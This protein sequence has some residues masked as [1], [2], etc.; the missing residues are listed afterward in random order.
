[1]LTLLSPMSGFVPLPSDF[2][3]S[4]NESMT[5][6]AVLT[7][8]TESV[9]EKLSKLNPN[10]AHVPDGI[11]SWLLKGNADLLAGLVTDIL[12]CSYR[13]GSGDSETKTHSRCKQ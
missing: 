1:M 10:K 4:L 11:Q 7:V 6:E 13:E 3:C 12:N 5:T 9:F 2:L 8:T